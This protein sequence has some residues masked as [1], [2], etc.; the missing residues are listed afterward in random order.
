VFHFLLL[1]SLVLIGSSV[2]LARFSFQQE[3]QILKDISL[4]AISIFSSLLAVIATAR[5]IPQE[6]EERTIYSILARR[7]QRMSCGHLR[8]IRSIFDCARH[9]AVFARA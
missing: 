5:L 2:A 1:F 8:A 4:G 3:F 9:K 7:I 6:I